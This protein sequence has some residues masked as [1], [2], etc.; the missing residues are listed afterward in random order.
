MKA[1]KPKRPTL[2]A[3]S[4]EVDRETMTFE[5]QMLAEANNPENPPA[6]RAYCAALAGAE[7]SQSL[8]AELARSRKRAA[9][10][11]SGAERAVRK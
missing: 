2:A 10:R 7:T 4:P 1:T 6:V 11:A 9:R 8:A 5:E 3:D